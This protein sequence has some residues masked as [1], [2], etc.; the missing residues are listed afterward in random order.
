MSKYSE[1]QD[2]L[3]QK[4]A[5]LGLTSDLTRTLLEC[6]HDLDNEHKALEYKV[7]ETTRFLAECRDQRD[8]ARS[9]LSRAREKLGAGEGALHRIWRSV[10][11]ERLIALAFQADPNRARICLDS[12]GG[13]RIAG[14]LRD[15]NLMQTE[16]Y[17]AR[18]AAS[19]AALG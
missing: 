7:Q 11:G 12:L 15:R 14:E 3:T 4:I 13:S 17:P 8:A 5:D 2:V 16:L 1:L 18:S 10:D 9:E 19:Q 6:C